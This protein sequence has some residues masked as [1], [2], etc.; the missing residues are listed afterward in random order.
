LAGNLRRALT[1]C[2]ESAKVFPSAP[3]DANGQTTITGTFVAG[4]CDNGG[5]R[6]SVL[7]P[8]PGGPISG[9][10]IC[11]T[12]CTIPIK[13]RSADLNG[14]LTVNLI[15]FSTFG[16]GYAS[17]PKPYNECADY[18]SPFGTITLGDFAT[19]AM[20]SGHGC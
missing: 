7:H 19:Y 3:T 13:V 1:P 8:I 17:P 18:F 4:G 10:L 16:L 5:V 14:D 12:E 15:D 2:G 20:H 9:G 6:V 11:E